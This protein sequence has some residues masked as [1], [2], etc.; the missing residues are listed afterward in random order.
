V[1]N[2]TIAC[3]DKVKNLGVVFD[4]TLSMQDHI[5]MVCSKGFYQLYRLR[6]IRKYVDTNSLETLVHAF[7]TSHLDYGNAMLYNIPESQLC[8]LQLLQNAAAKLLCNKRKFDSATECL[9]TLH[10]LP[11]KQR[12]MFKIALLVFKNKLGKLPTY[13]SC[14]IHEKKNSRSL[15]SSNKDLLDVPKLKGT[16]FGRRSFSFAAANVWN[17]LPEKLKQC[18]SLAKFKKDL[19]THLFQITFNK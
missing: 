6:Q 8:K 15:R 11:V 3:V 13:L 16:M 18:V 19:K 17:D 9:R 7:I 10:W 12:I 1:G 14:L 2:S 4:K 5:N